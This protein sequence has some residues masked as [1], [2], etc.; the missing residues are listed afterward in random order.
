MDL[1]WYKRIGVL[2]KDSVKF[3]S[4]FDLCSSALHYYKHFPDIV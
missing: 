2:R 3:L 4:V 1:I